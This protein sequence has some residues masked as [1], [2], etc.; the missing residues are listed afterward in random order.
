[1]SLKLDFTFQVLFN[2]QI[3]LPFINISDISVV[4]DNHAASLIRALYAG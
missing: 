4:S 1:L 3:V 2:C